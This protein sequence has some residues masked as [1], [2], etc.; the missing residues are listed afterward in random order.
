MAACAVAGC[1]EPQV[2]KRIYQE[3][4]VEA[5]PPPMTTA[6]AD[7]GMSDPHA[8]M[9][10]SMRDLPVPP[11]QRPE[12]VAEFTW[13]V[14]PGWQEEAGTG[15]RLA[16]LW[17]ESDLGRAECSL[18]V[19]T[20][21]TGGL[22]ANLARWM[23]QVDVPPLSAEAMQA[24]IGSLPPL[25]SAGGYEGVL[26]DFDALV[27]GADAPSTLAGILRRGS[28]TLFIKLTG[29]RRMLAQE[30]DRFVALCES[31]R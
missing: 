10:R 8:G 14:P 24:Y 1:S 25:Q 4:R 22:P 13:T 29:T 7:Q 6:A 3:I 12:G 23:D 21:D 28:E 15:M 19:L 27:A 17:V 5:P 11:V 20:G 18:I 2:P 26:V 9:D 31:V 30:R 16:T